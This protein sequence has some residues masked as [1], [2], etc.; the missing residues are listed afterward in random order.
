LN[1]SYYEENNKYKTD[2]DKSIDNSLIEIT[3]KNYISK[4]HNIFNKPNIA[5]II[6]SDNKL[7]TFRS[8]DILENK[9][10][11]EKKNIVD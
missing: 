9:I 8:V 2:I 6:S 1:I 5:N 10:N 4:S 3:N 11:S 7:P